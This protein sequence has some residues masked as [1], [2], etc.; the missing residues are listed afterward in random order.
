[1]NWLESII[2]GLVVGFADF[3]PVSSFAHSRILLKLFGETNANPLQDL[4][5]HIAL[6]LAVVQC[7]RTTFEHA[8]RQRSLLHNRGRLA[9]SDGNLELR[10]LKNAVF[11]MFITFF[12]LK[13]SFKFKLDLLWITVFSVINGVLLFSQGRMMQGN[14]DAKS[15]SAFDSILAGVSGCLFIFPGLSRISSVL[16][17]FTARGIS[18]V[19]SAEW[20][21][22]LSIPALILWIINDALDIFI[23]SGA[24]GFSGNIV[25]CLLS[26]IA[27]YAAGYF[28]IQTLKRIAAIRNFSG[29]AYYS[30]GIALF[31]FILYLAVV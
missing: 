25:S 12:V 16:T 20:A 13:Y 27:A 5:I 10:F 24:L 8:R 2:Y 21:V 6:L 18:R 15:L 28:G 29:F 19:K 30:W 31:S 22:L 11:P 1:M 4:L 3:L 23:S 26:A 14:K 9:F 7:N 17:V